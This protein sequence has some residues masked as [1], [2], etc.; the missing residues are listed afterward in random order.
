MK[1]STEDLTRPRGPGNTLEFRSYPYILKYKV[2]DSYISS[3]SLFCA[4]PPTY[5]LS[6]VFNDCV[7]RQISFVIELHEESVLVVWLTPVVTRA[8][9]TGKLLDQEGWFCGV[10]IPWPIS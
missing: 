7:F 6:I 8:L 3:E 2:Q 10:Q 9:V 1:L 5:F 4:A